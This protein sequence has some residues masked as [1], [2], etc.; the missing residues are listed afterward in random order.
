MNQISPAGVTADGKYFID[1][2]IIGVFTLACNLE[3]T[4]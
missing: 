3:L 1:G 2:R 4:H